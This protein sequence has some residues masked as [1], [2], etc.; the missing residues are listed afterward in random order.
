MQG[1]DASEPLVQAVAVIVLLDAL[2]SLETSVLHV[3]GAGTIA[4][5]GGKAYNQYPT[6]VIPSM[7]PTLMLT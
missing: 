3:C 4:L 7:T 2:L 6:L 1:L 5:A